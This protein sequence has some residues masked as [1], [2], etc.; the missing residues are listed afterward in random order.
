M[1]L[2]LEELRTQREL[3]LRQL[4]WI[5]SKIAGLEEAPKATG[6]ADGDATAE[7]AS[8]RPEGSVADISI[9]GESILRVKTASQVKQAQI[10]C[11]LLFIGAC[12]LFLF[13][14]FG[15]PYLIDTDDEPKSEATQQK[16]G[17]KPPPEFP[18]AVSPGETGIP[19][20][21]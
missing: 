1:K 15:L 10:G 3:I 16:D 2:S 17:L 4:R 9:P 12:S 13:L 8:P 18:E 5:E 19:A 6:P 11:L 21:P 7:N 14:L 20:A